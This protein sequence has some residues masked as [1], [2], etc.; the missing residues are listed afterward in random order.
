MDLI[1]GNAG[2]DYIDAGDDEVTGV[3][4]DHV[5]EFGQLVPQG[6]ANASKLV[7]IIE[8]LGCCLPDDACSTVR[9]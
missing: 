1:N 3:L 2:N 6:G 7:A 4:R 5:T 9:L 8:N